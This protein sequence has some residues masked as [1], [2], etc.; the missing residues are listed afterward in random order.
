MPPDLSPVFALS[1]LWNPERDTEAGPQRSPITVIIPL[2][3][4][5]EDY[6]VSFER[7]ILFCFCLNYL[8]V[9][10]TKSVF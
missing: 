6:D 7:G 5:H 1:L 10:G 3:V 8:K 9:Y 4:K 2:R